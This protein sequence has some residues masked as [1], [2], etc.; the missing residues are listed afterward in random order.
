MSHI[1]E[2]YLVLQTVKLQMHAI[3]AFQ[4]FYCSTCLSR[5]ACLSLH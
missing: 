1:H 5:C 2:L 3:T 4:P